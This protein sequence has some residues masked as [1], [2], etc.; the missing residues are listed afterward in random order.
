MLK[1]K[2]AF[3]PQTRIVVRESPKE[4]VTSPSPIS[5]ICEEMLTLRRDYC[6]VCCNVLLYISALAIKAISASSTWMFYTT[7]V[8]RLSRGSIKQPCCATLVCKMLVVI[9]SYSS[10]PQLRVSIQVF[11]DIVVVSTARSN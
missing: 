11:K 4:R 2:L 5:Y 1:L 10:V 8:P 9:L 7:F 6:I 3:T